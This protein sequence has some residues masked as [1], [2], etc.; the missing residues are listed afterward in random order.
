MQR[1]C[2][3]SNYSIISVVMPKGAKQTCVTH[4]LLLEISRC[5]LQEVK[6]EYCEG[7]HLLGHDAVSSGIY[8][9]R[10]FG[11]AC[12][13]HIQDLGRSTETESSRNVGNF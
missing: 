5:T 13:I 8:S 1:A 9:Y 11:R 7:S 6:R 3:K 2:S 4:A 12:C 10:Y